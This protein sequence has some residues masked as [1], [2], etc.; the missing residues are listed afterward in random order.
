MTNYIYDDDA[1]PLLPK[2]TVIH[3]TAWYDNTKAN[4]NN[5]DP[6]QWVGYGDRTVDEMAHAWMNVVYFNDDEYKALQAERKAKTAKTTNDERSSSEPIRRLV[7]RRRGRRNIAGG[8]LLSGQTTRC[9]SR[10][11]ASGASVTGAFEGWFYNQ[12]GSR[13]FLVGYYN[14]NSQQDTRHPDRAEQPDRAGRARHGA[15]DAFSARPAVGHV[16]RPRAEGVQA[17]R[18]LRL[19]D[20]RERTDAPAFRCGCNADYVM[21]PFTEIAVGNTPPVLRFEQN[22]KRR[23][24]S[25]S[26]ARDRAAADRVGRDA[27]AAHRLGRRRHEIHERHQRAADASRVRR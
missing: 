8:V 23:P 7:C 12:D 24:G 19:D 13:S 15:A 3:V 27:A 20:R 21:S 6:D 5:P 1:A 9:P 16:H 22:G 18:L 11:A 4:K 26:R 2:G 10:A 25:A 17:D 14:R